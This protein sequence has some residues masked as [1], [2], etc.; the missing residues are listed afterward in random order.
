MSEGLPASLIL[1]KRMLERV[2]E[3]GISGHSYVDE[4]GRWVL[5]LQ[6]S[7][8]GRAQLVSVFEGDSVE[9]AGTTWTVS[10]VLEPTTVERG[11]VATLTRVG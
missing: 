7:D 6:I 11:K 9:F 4:Q 8:G 2:D 5:Q 3:A 1:M 10:E